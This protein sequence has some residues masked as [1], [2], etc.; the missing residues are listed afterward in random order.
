[1]SSRT[2]L[3]AKQAAANAAKSHSTTKRKIKAI[4]IDSPLSSP[5]D[6]KRLKTS[7]KKTSDKDTLSI[8]IPTTL[9]P[10]PAEP[11]P[12]SNKQVEA[13]GE[14][15]STLRL[16]NALANRI[17]KQYIDEEIVRRMREYKVQFEFDDEDIEDAGLAVMRQLQTC[18]TETIECKDCMEL[19]DFKQFELGKDMLDCVVTCTDVKQILEQDPFLDTEVF[20]IPFPQFGPWIAGR[21]FERMIEEDYEQ[22]SKVQTEYLKGQS[23]QGD[24]IKSLAKMI[25]HEID[26]DKVKLANDLLKIAVTVRE[27]NLVVIRD[28]V[29]RSLQND[30]ETVARFAFATNERLKQLMSP[31]V[32]SADLM[33]LIK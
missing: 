29:A 20:G 12:E 13:R 19:F 8:T 31:G 25:T 16:F 10:A 23:S 5:R 28:E 33:K 30:Q 4:K 32:S 1:M 26:L 2:K 18:G 15:D 22:L 9:R 7:K 24:A 27:K 6:K 14:D 11:R 3:T 21:I 17:A